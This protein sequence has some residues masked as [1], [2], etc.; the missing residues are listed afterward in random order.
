MAFT[1]LGEGILSE[2]AEA[3]GDV[4]YCAA[5]SEERKVPRNW[6]IINT[7]HGNDVKHERRESGKCPYCGAQP[8]PGKK[9]CAKHL[10]WYRERRAVAEA[11]GTLVKKSPEWFKAYRGRLKASGRCARCPN[12]AKPG[13]TR[14]EACTLKARKNALRGS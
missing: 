2:F 1:D 13:R 9:H 10:E 14:C 11:N 12:P 4:P 6:H 7:N 3:Q 5:L 8:A